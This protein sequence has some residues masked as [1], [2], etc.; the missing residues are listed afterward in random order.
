MKISRDE[1]KPIAIAPRREV[2]RRDALK[3]IGA[4]VAALEAGCF[5]Q[6]G[7]DEIVPYVVDP[8]ELRPGVP[9]RYTGALVRDG[10][11][12]GVIVES[13]D[14]RPIKLDGNPLH[15]GALGGSLP[16]MQASIL[17][18]YD[19]QRLR[20]AELAG[21]P[22][23]WPSLAARLADP[24]RGALWIVMPPQSSPSIAAL[25]ARIAGRRELHV[26]YDAPLDRVAA[27][28]GSALAYGRPLDVQL[29]L[30]RADTIVALDAD[31]LAGTAMAPAWARAFAERRAP[32]PRMNR[33]WTCEP[34]P[35][36]TGTLA[37]ERLAV[38]AG[39]VS[40]IAALVLARLGELGLRAP[41]LARDALDNAR[42]RAGANGAAW[43]RSLAEELAA[44]RGAAAV[45]VGD[46][47]P[48]IAHALARWIDAA[49]GNVG[50]P[51]ALTA[52][53][54]LDP[55]G[56]RTLDELAAAASSGG[57]GAVV[58]VDAD[59]LYTAPHGR[60]LA[61]ALERV[62]LRVHVARCAD[63][64]AP[65]CNATMPLAHDLE[66]W[67]DARAWTGELTIGQ[68]AIRPR[69]PVASTLDVL[70][71][72]AGDPRRPREIVRA[73][74]GGDDARWTDALRVGV[75]RG[76]AAP[77]I[78]LAEPAWPRGANAELMRALDGGAA[79]SIQI[80]I[81]LA[82][83][84]AVHDGR[85]AGN[86]WLQE[87]PHPITKQTWGNAALMAPATADAL[88]V[89]DG[90]VVRVATHIAAIELPAVIVEGAAARS[91]T[92]ELGHGRRVA[93]LPVGDG[94]GVDAYPLRTSGELVLRGTAR[95]TGD[96]ARVVRT[97]QTTTLEGRELAPVVALAELARSPDFVAH[98]RGDQPSLLPRLPKT[99]LGTQWGMSID[100]S[101]C[102]ACG[103]CMVACQAENNIPSVGP[104]DVARGRHMNWI[105][106]DRYVRDDGEVVNEPMPCQHC[107]HAPCEYVC[108][109]MATTHSADGLNEQTYNRCIGTRFCS[110]NCPYKVRRFNWFAFESSDDRALQYNPDV[111]VRSRGVMEKCTYCVQRIRRAEHAALV[112]DRAIRPGEVVT[113]CQQACPTGAIV[114]GELH[115]RGTRFAALRRDPRRFEALHD[116]GTRPRTQ[117]LA[118]VK[119][120]RTDR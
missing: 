13:R 10:Y 98:L 39:A 106:V 17:D 53:V 36:P 54:L 3:L 33:L 118:K 120:P 105:R 5:E 30:A 92:I 47:Q 67:S 85:D 4:G 110:N 8:P 65:H 42:L 41:P 101:L 45:I 6:A 25:L 38:P 52:P 56:A 48:A 74:L 27:H 107:E 9:T 71:A 116:L 37:D 119:N 46:R 108:P 2:T 89:D 16:W 31:L 14:G 18:V 24:P 49:C 64:T 15:P 61:D 72:L 20:D 82:R 12:T 34:M 75:V 99:T 87:L 19:P 117:Y 103:A 112:E 77:P 114:F 79:D 83:S 84:P 29:D 35:T 11:A 43:A 96:R 90:D 62:P 80:E 109:V 59:P 95:A 86:A 60:A 94:V 70:A 58:I 115:E 66:T 81:A 32:G 102:T 22:T 93:G 28:R 113:A 51:V 1:S 21:A 40:A 104:D 7:E 57:V 76:T 26:V 97:Q 69:F 50:G 100:T 91:I 78:A 111:T 44:R 68:P 63:E 55:L 23:S 73:Q 88:G